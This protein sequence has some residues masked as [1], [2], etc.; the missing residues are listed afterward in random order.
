MNKIVECLHRDI[1]KSCFTLRMIFYKNLCGILEHLVT[2][3]NQKTI[4][5]IFQNLVKPLKASCDNN[6][7]IEQNQDE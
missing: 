6:L 7:G 1:N 2:F 4:W 5:D 3:L